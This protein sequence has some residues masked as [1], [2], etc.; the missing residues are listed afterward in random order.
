[1]KPARIKLLKCAHCDEQ[2]HSR[3]K[4]KGDPL[5]GRHYTQMHDYGRILAKTGYDQN[6]IIAIWDD[7]SLFE[8][9]RLQK[10]YDKYGD[11]ILPSYVLNFVQIIPYPMNVALHPI[12][13][14]GE[15]TDYHDSL[16]RP[17]GVL[18]GTDIDRYP[19]AIHHFMIIRNTKN[20]ARLVYRYAGKVQFLTNFKRRN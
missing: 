14:I 3:L 19:S 6:E 16:Y 17:R 12:R 7:K 10:L 15:N 11:K 13:T 1:M 4:G 8:A 2:A 20:E 5:C 9:D 18:G